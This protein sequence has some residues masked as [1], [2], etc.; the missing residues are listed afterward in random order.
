MRT[1]LIDGDTIIF[2]AASSSEYECELDA[3][4]DL[5]WG[6]LSQA[7]SYLKKDIERIEEE[8]E[9]DRTIIALSHELRFRPDVMPEYKFNRAG[10]RKPVNYKRLRQYVRDNY[11]FYEKPYLEGD[12][13]LGILMTHPKV[14]EGYKII[15]A[16][17]KDLN[18][19]PGPH[20]NYEKDEFYEVSEEEADL[21]FYK[22]VLMG[23]TTDG[24]KGCK[25]VGPKKAEKILAPFAKGEMGHPEVWQTIV[26]TYEAAEMTEEDALMNARVARIL[27]AHEYDYKENKPILWT[28]ASK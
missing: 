23:D 17:D 20:Y 16:I 21:F 11:E 19:I 6:N 10:S 26:E 18:T 14:V 22:Q 7:I 27:H 24:Y 25:G 4:T 15:V 1:A 3:W 13:V 12:D 5:L 9:V 2:A 28:P 8:L